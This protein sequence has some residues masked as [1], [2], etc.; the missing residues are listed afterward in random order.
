MT[1]KIFVNSRDKYLILRLRVLAAREG[2]S[3]CESINE[4][5]IS[6]IIWDT[7]QPLLKLQDA[8]VARTLR[9]SRDPS[10]EA[11]VH[12]P[13][14]NEEL[15]ALL[16][17]KRG[18]ARLLL[19]TNERCA[20]LDQKQIRLTEIE[21]ALL[22]LLIEAQGEYVSHEDAVERIWSGDAGTGAVNVY[23]HYLREKL[24]GT[25]ERIILAKR[26]RGYAIDKKFLGGEK[27]C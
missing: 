19:D 22:S 12:L 24:E 14:A 17:G 20:Y 5:G 25:G 21:S 4:D 15:S 7:E 16:R 3:L 26:G 27:K 8:F 1:N 10:I 6:L 18:E 11:D 2:L 9:L 13:V 23:I